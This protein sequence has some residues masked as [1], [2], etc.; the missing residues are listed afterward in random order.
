MSEDKVI[1]VDEIIGTNAYIGG[2]LQP[3]MEGATYAVSPYGLHNT[4][5]NP[6]NDQTLG[7][8]PVAEPFSRYLTPVNG[9]LRFVERGVPTENEHVLKKQR[10]LQVWSWSSSESKY[11]WYDVP[12][13]DMG[14]L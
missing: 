14:P 6:D 3:K 1:L 13:V 10:I 7:Y 8:G 2:E 9:A 5:N 11:D 4:T 12:L